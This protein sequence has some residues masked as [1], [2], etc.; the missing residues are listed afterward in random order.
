MPYVPYMPDMPDVPSMPDG[1]D[2]DQDEGGSDAWFLPPRCE[3]QP[4]DAPGF[5]GLPA[6]SQAEAAELRRVL[7]LCAEQYAQRTL[8]AQELNTI[9]NCI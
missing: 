9:D 3:V 7:D 1:G 6:E 2:Q 5:Q 4:E 8:T